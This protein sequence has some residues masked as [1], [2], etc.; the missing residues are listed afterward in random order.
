MIFL[1]EKAQSKIDIL[2]K[3]SQI[4]IE[5]DFVQDG[6][7][8]SVLDREKITSTAVG[9]KVAI[10]H[11]AEN[12]VKKS[13]IAIITL[14]DPIKW[15][16]EEVDIIFLL[17]LKVEDKKFIKSF[18]SHFSS[19]LHNDDTLRKIRESYDKNE[20]VGLLSVW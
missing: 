7:N 10:P 9:K 20:I 11:G 4:F 6:F 13:C 12:L 18:F 5:K 3:V 1:K 19:I 16:E 14:E 2:S 17:A 15:G 8:N